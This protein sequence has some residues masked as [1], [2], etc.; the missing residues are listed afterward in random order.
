MLLE[1]TLV[2]TALNSMLTIDKRIVF[3]TILVRMGEGYL[4]ILALK[5][6]NGI[7]CIVRHTVFQQVFQSVS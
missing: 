1:S 3:L 2:C 4:D 6:N 7:E 5:M